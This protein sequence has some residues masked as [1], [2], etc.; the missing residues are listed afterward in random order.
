MVHQELS[1]DTV[2]I[3]LWE[4]QDGLEGHRRLPP[5]AEVHEDECEKLVRLLYRRRPAAQA[6]DEHFEALLI[7]GRG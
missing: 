1:I 3:V 5:E 4:F 2:E 6:W 7:N